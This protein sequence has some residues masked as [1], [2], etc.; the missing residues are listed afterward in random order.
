MN[1][2]NFNASIKAFFKISLKNIKIPDTFIN[3]KT[4]NNNYATRLKHQIEK[5]NQ[6]LHHFIFKF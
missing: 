1:A 4:N 3:K 5:E 6:H 2:P